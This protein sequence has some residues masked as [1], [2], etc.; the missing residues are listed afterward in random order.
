M[1]RLV[2]FCAL[3]PHPNPLPKGEGWG[4]GESAFNIHT[5]RSSYASFP[6]PMNLSSVSVAGATRRLP[7][8]K[9]DWVERATG[10]FWRATRPTAERVRRYGI[11][12]R[13]ARKTRR[14]VAAEDGQVGRATRNKDT[15][16]GKFMGSKRGNFRGILT[17]TL[18]LGER[19]K[20]FRRS[21]ADSRLLQFL[22]NCRTRPSNCVQEK[23]AVKRRPHEGE[24][25]A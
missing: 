13:F 11:A 20:H 16:F 9:V 10:P 3:P 23:A 21:P 14:Q 4:E 8:Q 6:L 12:E 1:K 25:C 2:I 7:F 15:H 17:S 19:E 24:M 18:S 5:R 22:D